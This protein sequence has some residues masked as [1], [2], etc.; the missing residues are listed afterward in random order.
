MSYEDDEDIPYIDGVK[1][2]SPLKKRRT[3][4][5]SSND[6]SSVGDLS[7]REEDKENLADGQVSPRIWKKYF[8]AGGSGLKLFMLFTVLILSQ[9]VCS[10]SDYF[11]N[12]WTQQEYLRGLD[13]P[14]ELTTYQ[15]LYIYGILI[16]C[17]VFMTVLRGYMFFS[18]C[19]RAS[20]VLHNRMFKSI[21]NATMRFF[22]TNPSGRILNRFS[23]DMA[24]LSGLSTIRA[25]GLQDLVIKEFDNLQDV[26]SGAWHLTKSLNYAFGLW[27]D[28]V[29]C[30]FL[31]AVTFSFLVGDS[32]E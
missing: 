21:L 25:R 20:K 30:A 3:S 18:I 17:V 32:S 16:L 14:T 8:T 23:K 5:M 15:C 10:G 4:S 29:S 27:L 6:K 22:D 31:T 26:H 2:Y 11:S 1:G 7:V 24:T 13:E 9:V 12:Y 28:I 19:M